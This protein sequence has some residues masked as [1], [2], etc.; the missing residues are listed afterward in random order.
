MYSVSLDQKDH[1]HTLMYENPKAKKVTDETLDILEKR[2]FGVHDISKEMDFSIE[3]S[4]TFSPVR[5]EKL[6][7]NNPTKLSSSP[8]IE[9]T[10]EKTQD[11]IYR[12]SKEGNTK[13]LALNFA[14]PKNPG[15]GFVR[16][17]VAQEED[18]C[19]ASALYPCLVAPQC[20]TY[21]TRNVDYIN[22]HSDLKPRPSPDGNLY[23]N[24]MIYSP[25]VPF[26]R[27]GDNQ[28]TYDHVSLCSVITSPAP[29]FRSVELGTPVSVYAEVFD[30]RIEAILALAESKRHDCLVL[31]AFGCGVFG[32]DPA[33]VANLFKKHLESPRFST[34]FAHVVFAVYDSKGVNTGIFKEILG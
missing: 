15:G 17:T 31:G 26:F 23:T 25:Q 7:A 22:M 5:L 28:L 20:E 33:F 34:S 13:L 3:N 1:I 6:V 8:F 14:S 2:I 24:W 4:E 11:A 30:K 32:N 10:S 21:Y 16:G 12:L 18:I 19:R 29:H 9:V 27:T